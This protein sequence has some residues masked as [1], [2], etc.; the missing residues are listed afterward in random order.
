L[1][2]IKERCHHCALAL[3]GFAHVLYGALESVRAVIEQQVRNAE[4]DRPNCA[5][6]GRL[7]NGGNIDLHSASERMY[8]CRDCTVACASVPE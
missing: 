2:E 1:T 8:P 5:A 4:G 6:N 3:Q 7:R